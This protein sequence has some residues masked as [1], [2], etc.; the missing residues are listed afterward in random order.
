MR[1]S[2]LPALFPSVAIV[3]GMFLSYFIPAFSLRLSLTAITILAVAAFL[4]FRRPKL[5]PFPVYAAL[6]F[7][8]AFAMTLAKGKARVALPAEQVAVEGTIIDSPRDTQNSVMFLLYIQKGP[9]T[10]KKIRC[11]AP[12]EAQQRLKTGGT[13]SL[14]GKLY[15]FKQW[16]NNIHFNYPRWAE[17]RSLIAQMKVYEGNL[18]ET[19]CKISSLPFAE[20]ILLKAKLLRSGVL[21]LFADENIPPDKLA[22]V[23][24]MAFGER[25]SISQE[26]WKIFKKTGVSHLLALSGLHLSIICFLLRS[27][28]FRLCGRLFGGAIVVVALWLYALIT[29]MSLSTIRAAMMLSLYILF[30]ADPQRTASANTIFVIIT[31]MLLCNPL[32]IWDIGFQLSVFSV[33]SIACFFSPIFHLVGYRFLFNHSLFKYIW[34]SIAV[35]IAAGFG[36]FPLI[37]YYFY[38]LSLLS[39]IIN[40]AAVPLATILLQ[41]VFMALVFHWLPP[42][43]LFFLQLVNISSGAL[44]GLLRCVGSWKVVSVENININEMQ[45]LFAYLAVAALAVIIRKLSATLEKR[46]ERSISSL[47]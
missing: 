10:G 12:K 43:K 6:V 4:L 7:F 40:I 11:Y 27:V 25:S 26:T 42:F 33:L 45:L 24:A 3:A 30:S 18:R 9:F 46:R 13:Y 37:M 17:S 34:G 15:E 19:G 23:S 8:G 2:A 35:T 1:I 47:L 44:S 28:F 32:M 38:Y 36:T 29:G 41:S 14:K 39:I 20:R 31:V 22:L 21:K 16:D 5:R